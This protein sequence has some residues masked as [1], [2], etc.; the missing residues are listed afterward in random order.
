MAKGRWTHI[1]KSLKQAGRSARGW[2]SLIFKPGEGN[3]YRT[4]CRETTEREG[5]SFLRGFPKRKVRGNKHQF[6]VSAD[7]HFGIEST[8]S[9]LLEVDRAK[10]P[11]GGKEPIALA[12]VGFGKKDVVVEVM[13]GA[14]GS[15][16][17]L[18][19]FRRAAQGT[20]ALN[21][22]VNRI[23]G[24]A[25]RLGF[26]KVKIRVPESLGNYWDPVINNEVLNT[27]KENSA[28]RTRIR[29]RMRELYKAVADAEGYMRKGDFYV[30]KL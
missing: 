12:G 7:S 9:I 27:K 5:R 22:L 15:G 3:R 4:A 2:A 21:Y 17:L 6:V 24:Q 13:Q 11:A 30:K 16:Q 26:K 1:G 14:K 8:A 29:E 20:P 10:K 28:E 25:K 18:S 23:E 19:E